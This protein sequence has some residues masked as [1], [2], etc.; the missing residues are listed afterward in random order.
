LLTPTRKTQ[1]D[2]LD[3]GTPAS[4]HSRCPAMR[5]IAAQYV[6]RRQ[7]KATTLAL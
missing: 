2:S 4:L 7:N 6:V 5:Q 1:R 3:T